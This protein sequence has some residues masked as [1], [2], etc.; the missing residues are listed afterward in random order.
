MKPGKGQS[1][2]GFVVGLVMSVI[3]LSVVIPMAGAFGILWT[4]VAVG[5]TVMHGLNVFTDKGVFSHE[6][7]IED[8]DVG[9]TES[10]GKT[11]EAEKG[12]EYEPGKASLRLEEVKDLYEKGLITAEE[13]EAKRKQILEE[14]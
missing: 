3:G 4:L 13:Y 10:G 7:M 1:A 8:R 12:E 5:I 11:G 2:L 9:E 14:L 6:I